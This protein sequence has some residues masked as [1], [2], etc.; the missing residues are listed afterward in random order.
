M[1]LILSRKIIVPIENINLSHPLKTNPY[2]E[3]KP[4]M[5]RIAKQK[6]KIKKQLGIIKARQREI[7][8]IIYNMKE[9]FILL[10]AKG[11]V[12]SFNAIALEYLNITA[13][14]IVFEIPH[15]QSMNT[16]ITSMLDDTQGEDRHFECVIGERTL[17]IVALPVRVNNMLQ[18]LALLVIDKSAQKQ[19]EDLRKSFS[20]NVT[21]ELKTPLSVILA[22]SEMLKSGL[23]KQGD[24]Q[25]FLTKIYIESKRLSTLIDN[26]LRL[27]FF[28]ENTLE[29]EKS[30]VDLYE[31]CKRVQKNLMPLAQNKNI[32]IYLLPPPQSKSEIWGISSLIEDMVYNLVENAI[33][34]SYEDSTITISLSH[35]EQ[36]ITLSVKDEGIGIPLE[37]QERIFERFY[38]VDKSRSKKLGGSG[39]GLSIVKHIV[40]IHNARIKLVSKVGKGT[41][42]SVEFMPYET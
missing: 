38:C 20:A 31:I 3:L 21:H 23:V 26:I 15:L 40:G 12:R 36:Y 24:E 28:D 30:Y 34:Y 14:D 16:E 42:M 5:Q 37:E 11:A 18:A 6:K 9:G 8:M 32:H 39:L 4:F 41:S 1:A 22:S 29:L 19:A 27:S 25:S 2:P 33:K 7:E 35:K 10:D 13:E 17:Y